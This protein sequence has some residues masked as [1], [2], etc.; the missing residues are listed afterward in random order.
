[1][2]FSK[3]NSY[4]KNVLQENFTKLLATKVYENKKTK[5]EIKYNDVADLVAENKKFNFLKGYYIYFIVF[6]VFILV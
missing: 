5:D 4:K 2:I 3:V 1:M 6:I